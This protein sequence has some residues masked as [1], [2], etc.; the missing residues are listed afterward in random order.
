MTVLKRLLVVVALILA[1]GCTSPQDQATGRSTPPSSEMPAPSADPLPDLKAVDTATP[2][3]TEPATLPNAPDVDH[4][5]TLARGSSTSRLAGET[6]ALEFSQLII[7]VRHNVDIESVVADVASDVLPKEERDALIHDVTSQH[8]NGLGRRW[9]TEEAM[10]IRSATEGPADAPSRVNVAIAGVL[11]I[12]NS[13]YVGWNKIR[14]DVVREAG[15]WRLIKLSAAPFRP[16][17]PAVNR[18]TARLG[19]H[20]RG[21]GWREIAPGH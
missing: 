20:L 3:K 15:S 6:F 7:D 4:V 2:S 1:A 14:I 9:K 12:A 18:A 16:D 5:V 17:D 11:A 10:W 19:D 13:D 8:A 21:P